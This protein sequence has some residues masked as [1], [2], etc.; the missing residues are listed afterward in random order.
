M[1]TNEELNDWVKA[2][3]TA[4]D[5]QAFAALFRHFAP[6]VKAYLVRSGSS[7]EVAEELAQETL[8]LLWRRASTFD[9][10]YA[11]VSTWLFTIARNVRIDYFRRRT[12]DLD[13][14]G[15]GLDAW[16]TDP[17]C[18][19]PGPGPEEHALAMQRAVDVRRALAALP[20][21]QVRVLRLSFFDEH[22]H[23]RIAQE[24][25]IPLGTV[26]SRIRVAVSQLRR[27]LDESGS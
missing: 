24:L 18:A 1:P 10:H 4:A 17:P 27:K 12:T 15:D 7:P 5:R 20:A 9:P 13:G 2:V 19:D 21:D 8:V 23:A 6:R 16:E 22:P 14:S 3:A 11:G 25:G 26:K